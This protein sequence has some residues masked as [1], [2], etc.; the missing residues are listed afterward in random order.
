MGTNCPREESSETFPLLKDTGV[1]DRVGGTGKS[2]GDA[3]VSGSPGVSGGEGRLFLFKVSRVSGK[4]SM[5]DVSPG[6]WSVQG[7]T[8]VAS[9]IVLIKYLEDYLFG[10][11]V[12]EQQWR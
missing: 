8:V 7:L 12:R 4:D 1:C 9:V 2:Q 11:G 6:S 10:V 3:G 5:A